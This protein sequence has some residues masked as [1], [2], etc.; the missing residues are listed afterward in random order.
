MDA[1]LR[2]VRVSVPHAT[3]T[4]PCRGPRALISG[5][6][7]TESMKSPAA[8]TTIERPSR[9]TWKPC[10]WVHQRPT[11][12]AILLG[13]SCIAALV[14]VRIGVC[15]SETDVDHAEDVS[16]T[17]HADASV[18]AIPTLRVGIAAEA[19]VPR[20]GPHLSIRI[21]IS[22]IDTLHRTLTRRYPRCRRTASASRPT[23]PH[24]PSH[25]S[26][27]ATPSPTPHASETV[28]AES[29]RV[30]GRVRATCPWC[31]VWS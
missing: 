4:R 8:S 3:Q 1:E 13:T 12:V 15:T 20:Q 30:I 25:R 6:P 18:S 2:Q 22:N 24:S 28:L 7:C 27:A 29:T 14:D 21:A 9:A 10:A 16:A 5:W 19:F 26:V 17:P 23:R 31:R 11:D